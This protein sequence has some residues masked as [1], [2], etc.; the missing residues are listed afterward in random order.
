M[1]AEDTLSLKKALRAST[2]LKV[3]FVGAGG[4]TTAMFQLAREMAPAIVTAST[5]LAEEQLSLADQHIVATSDADIKGI[6]DELP[7]GVTVVTGEMKGDG[8]TQGLSE[9]LLRRLSEIATNHHIPLL[10]EADGSRQRPVKAPAEH[11]PAIPDFVNT[12]VVVAGLAGIGHP[13]KEDFV[14][15]PEHFAALSGLTEEEAVKPPGYFLSI[16][17]P[18]RRPQEYPRSCAACRFIEPSRYYR[19]GLDFRTYGWRFIEGVRYSRS[20][21]FTKA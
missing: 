3:A 6:A 20:G 9:E 14:H 4:K 7:Q 2:D 12:V 21:I 19:V 11:E 10:V 18:Q 17:A 8:R 5:H 16:V 13:L 1:K 15:R